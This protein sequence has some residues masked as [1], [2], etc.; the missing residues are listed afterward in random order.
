MNA[1]ELSESKRDTS[2]RTVDFL[3]A[4]G[5]MMS[6]RHAGQGIDRA[7]LGFSEAARSAFSFLV[8]DYGFRLMES[9]PTYVRYETEALVLN[10]YHGRI[11]YEIDVEIGRL[12]ETERCRYRLPDVL[13]AL[14]GLEDKRAT[15]FQASNKSAVEK[16]VRAIAG[17]V[18][19]HYAP[20]LR[21]EPA[22]FDSIRTYTAAR[23]AAY[24]KEV[25]Q[26]P[27]RAAAD[28]AWRSKNY[29]KVKELYGSIRSDLSVVERKRLDYAE[30]HTG[31]R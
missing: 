21:G 23:D 11:S 19:R 29:E 30:R 12:P 31:D 25:A 17:L 13:G 6:E 28:D 24:T 18:A 15:Y 8:T 22:V 14:A 3:D 4:P 26:R 2:S 16:C 10:V 7:D 20:V 1:H 27:V 5:A 9:N